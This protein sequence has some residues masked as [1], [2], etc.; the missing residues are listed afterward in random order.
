MPLITP[1]LHL[2]LDF[3]TDLPELQ[4]NTI[5][6]VITDRVSCFLCLILLLGLTTA[7]GTVDIIFKQVFRYFGIPG[8][9]VI[10]QDVQ[11]TFRVWSFVEKPGDN[12]NLT[13]GYHP[14]WAGGKG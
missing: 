6:L 1:W 11:F 8:N 2:P 9:I 12:V 14:K 7:T 10:A 4:V 5:I 13:S 3:L